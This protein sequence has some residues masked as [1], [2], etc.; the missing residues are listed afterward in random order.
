[1]SIREIRREILRC[2]AG[3]RAA[4]RVSDWALAACYS[5]ELAYL[6]FELDAR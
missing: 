6:Y 2:K 3:K 4:E 5:D 1:M